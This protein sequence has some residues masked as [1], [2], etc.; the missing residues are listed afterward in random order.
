MSIDTKHKELIGNFFRQGSYYDTSF[1]KVKDHDF[2][3]EAEA[4]M[5]PHGIYDLGDNQGYLSL[6][7]SKDTSE[8]VCDNI[9]AWWESDLQWK[10]PEANWALILCD[11]GGSN[12]S[13]SYLVKQDFYRL[14]Q[15]LEIN[16][17]IAHY[18]AYCSKYN[19][20]EHRFFCHLHRA[21][22]GAVFHNLQIPLT[23]AQE[24]YTQTG[25]QVKARLNLKTYQT[26][27]T[28]CPQFREN[29]NQYVHF[30]QD[31]PQWN[32]YMS[33]QKREVIF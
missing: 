27:R 15:R 1:R 3:S 30:D 29:L 26:Q 10:Y 2:R 33:P 5:V 13:R 28:V 8:F 32:Y 11:G 31:I 22:E 6:G 12:N 16:L 23:L 7:K 9:E 4:I 20:I 18:P 25:L 24:T 19:P 14:A 21:W 17:L